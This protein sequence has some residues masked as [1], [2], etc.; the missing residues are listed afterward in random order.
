MAKTREKV[1]YMRLRFHNITDQTL[2]KSGSV[3]L[4]RQEI[5]DAL[6]FQ[7]SSATSSTRWYRNDNKPV[8]VVCSNAE[9]ATSWVSTI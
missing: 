4:D 5:T 6:Y 1:R 3:K 8:S 9:E 2:S 7:K